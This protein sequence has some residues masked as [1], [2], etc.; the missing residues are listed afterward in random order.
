MPGNLEESRP[1][2]HGANTG[3]DVVLGMMPLAREL[4]RMGS[5]VIMVANSLPAI[6]DVTCAELRTLLES[7]CDICPV[8]KVCPPVEAKLMPKNLPVDSPTLAEGAIRHV[9]GAYH[10][11]HHKSEHC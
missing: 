2:L 8:L 3:A 9:Q 6:N 5:E 7:V 4:L 11:K 1:E 10:E